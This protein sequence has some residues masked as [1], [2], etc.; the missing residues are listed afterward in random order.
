[1]LGLLLLAVL[2][3]GV[4]LI[5]ES[6]GG[7]FSSY[8]LVS[9]ELPASATAVSLNAPV[10]YRNVQV[11]TV[12]SQGQSV[13]GGLVELTLHIDPSQLGS[14]PAGVEATEAPVSVFGDPDLILAPPANLNGAA[15][16]AGAV[17]PALT[18]GA[19][20]SLQSTLGD[21]DTLLVGLHPADLDAAL[22]ALAGALQ[23]EGASLGQN[24]DKANTYLIQMLPLWPTVVS[25]LKT[26]VPVSNQF[27]ASTANIL[28]ILSNQTTTGETIASDASG[29]NEALGGGAQ[30]AAEATQLLQD[31]EQ[32]YAVLA[33]DA[34]SFFQAVSQSPTEISRLLGGLDA[35]AKAWTAAEASGPYLD[36]ETDVVVANPAD[37]GLAVLGGP[38]VDSYLSG[39][40]GAGYVNP[41]TYSGAGTITT[42]AVSGES[43]TGE[44]LSSLASAPTPVMA[45]PAETTAVSQI[46]AG[47]TGSAPANASVATLLLGPVL[48]SLVEGR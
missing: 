21:L 1:M 23:G 25:D 35:W 19:T 48:E 22:T 3:G 16:Q 27:A 32:P 8:A 10:E 26:L 31:I 34:G 29:V 2:L 14:I 40:L 18:T 6:F 37:L 12:A 42:A 41:A 5:F 13:P 20:A 17:I 15:L 11:G 36:L 39:G 45:E 7:S 44:L 4:V 46:V 47:A 24:L 30:L 38:D 33:A 43:A 9:A 28:T